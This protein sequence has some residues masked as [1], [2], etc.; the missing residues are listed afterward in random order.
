MLIPSRLSWSDTTAS[1]IGR[2]W[3]RHTP[4]LPPHFPYIPAI[5]FAPRKS[6]A[7]FLAA[8]FTGMLIC[9]GFWWGGSGTQKHWAV[10]D[11]GVWG[12]LATAGF[13]GTGGAV[14]EALGKFLFFLWIYRKGG[15]RGGRG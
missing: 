9:I 15:G 10:L 13:V 11:S 14:V 4:P 8:T 1:T 5:K 7:G 3:G 6:L 2:L 12:L